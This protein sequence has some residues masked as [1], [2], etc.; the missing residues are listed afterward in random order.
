MFVSSHLWLGV[1]LVVGF[2]FLLG[3]FCLVFIIFF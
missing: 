1:V 2:G 3:P